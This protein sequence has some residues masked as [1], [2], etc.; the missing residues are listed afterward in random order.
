M[1]LA[2]TTSATAAA[3]GLPGIEIVAEIRRVLIT[4]LLAVFVYS[5]L[6]VASRSYCPGGFDGSGGFI[7]S[8]GQ[9]TDQ[10]PVCIDLA[11][12]PSPMVYIGIAAIV[13]ITLGRVMKASDEASALGTLNR[14]AIGIAALV[15]VAII[16][17]LFWFFQIPLEGFTSGSWTVFSP[18]PF[19]SID[20]TSTPLRAG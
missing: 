13:L 6:M 2:P 9:S 20:V 15:G 14:A 4:T 5:S 16:V 7:D 12:R 1:S 8:D 18:F 17:S 10:A 11:L 3:T 19:G